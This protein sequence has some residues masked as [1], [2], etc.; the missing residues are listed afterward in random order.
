MD[1]FKDRKNSPVVLDVGP[2]LNSSSIYFIFW[3]VAVLLQ[4]VPH[5]PLPQV[6]MPVCSSLSH[7]GDAV[8]IPRRG[9]K[10]VAALSPLAAEKGSFCVILWGCPRGMGLGPPANS[11]G[12][13]EGS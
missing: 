12:G 2:N 8:S 7:T 4:D 10:P 6:S 9:H 11:Q 3:A 1:K 13:A 5:D